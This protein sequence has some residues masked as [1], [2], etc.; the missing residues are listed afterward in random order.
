MRA[1]TA[2]HDRARGCEQDAPKVQGKSPGG[3][4]NLHSVCEPNNA[5]LGLSMVLY[6]GVRLRG[7]WGIRSHSAELRFNFANPLL[8]AALDFRHRCT[9]AEVSGLVKVLQVGAQFQQ[10]LLGKPLSH[11]PLIVHLPRCRC[12]I[13]CV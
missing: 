2:P 1:P 8:E 5:G 4:R 12:K 13:T 7:D 9:L 6:C 11:S 10:K 3:T